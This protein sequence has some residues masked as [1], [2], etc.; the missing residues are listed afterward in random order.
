MVTDLMW[1]VRKDEVLSLETLVPR[2]EGE[3]GRGGWQSSAWI[4]NFLYPSRDIPW[5]TGDIKFRTG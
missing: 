5:L 2:M 1:E 4:I 3:T